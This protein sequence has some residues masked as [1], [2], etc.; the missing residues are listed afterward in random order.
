MGDLISYGSE[1]GFE[2]TLM[3]GVGELPVPGDAQNAQESGSCLYDVLISVPINSWS[4]DSSTTSVSRKN[5]QH[6]LSDNTHS[7]P[8]TH[9]VKGFA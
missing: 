5:Q 6:L 2:Y 1:P 9:S 4:P 3:P 7:A 8:R